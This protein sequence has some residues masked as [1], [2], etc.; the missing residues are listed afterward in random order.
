MNATRNYRLLGL[1]LAGLLFS[2]ALTQGQSIAHRLEAGADSSRFGASVARLGDL[3]QDGLPEFIVGDPKFAD[4]NRVIGRAIVYSGRDASVLFECHGSVDGGMFGEAVAGAG[5]VN[6]DG[7]E[8]WIVGEEMNDDV[9]FLGGK[10][11]VFSGGD[12][13]VLLELLP[14]DRSETLGSSVGSAG[15]FDGDGHDDLVVGA[16]GAGDRSFGQARVFSGS[17]GRLLRVFEV[18]QSAT[19]AYGVAVASLGDLDGD[20][21]GELAVGCLYSNEN[22]GGFVQ[23]F[24]GGSG[25]LLATLEAPSAFDDFGTALDGSGDLN[26]DGKRD[27]VVGARQSLHSGTAPGYVHAYSGSDWSLLFE[28]TG[29]SADDRFGVEV[30]GAGDLDGDGCD[31]VIIGASGSDVNAVFGGTVS[32]HSGRDGSPLFEVQGPWERSGFG[33]SLAGIGDFDGN[34]VVDF[35]AGVP[36]AIWKD[37]SG[38]WALIFA[39]PPVLLNSTTHRELGRVHLEVADLAPFTPTFL[40]YSKLGRGRTLLP[41]LLTALDLQRAQPVAPPKL[42]DGAGRAEWN[43][44][45][46]PRAQGNWIWVQAAQRG[47]ATNVVCLELP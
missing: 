43:A 46:P 14:T 41:R 2:P 38:G 23:V 27:L 36:S 16:V 29:S 4:S 26:G 42:T 17:D 9:Y 18:D 3:D 45:A 40:Y 28:W 21:R 32:V 8:D 11:W 10:A 44:E 25:T 31:E 15:D 5:D 1:T 37:G 47:L 39:S 22:P 34:G 7:I 24:V 12:G 19:T 6:A 30:S 35:V 33:K 13:S 20:G